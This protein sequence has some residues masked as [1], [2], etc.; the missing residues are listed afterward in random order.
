MN[1]NPPPTSQVKLSTPVDLAFN[2][3]R[4]VAGIHAGDVFA[5]AKA[6]PLVTASKVV[7]VISCN[8]TAPAVLAAALA[9]APLGTKLA[10]VGSLATFESVVSSPRFFMGNY[11]EA[12]S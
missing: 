6:V 10:I 9:G 4:S 7:A 1:L 3:N 11:C 12:L 2:L 5:A 8:D